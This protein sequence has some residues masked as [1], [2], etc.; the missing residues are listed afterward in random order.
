MSFILL[1]LDK[2]LLSH[3]S[4]GLACLRQC[5]YIVILEWRL[6]RKAFGIGAVNLNAMNGDK[7]DLT[8]DLEYAN[9]W[10]PSRFA[11]LYVYLAALLSS[12]AIYLL[13]RIQSFRRGR[14]E[15]PGSWRTK[16]R[17]SSNSPSPRRSRS[18]SRNK[19]YSKII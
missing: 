9:L 3:C 16:R 8:I 7:N 19:Y 4:R 6:H 1:P 12:A 10:L 2:A 18:S 14:R 5:V 11:L 13:G 17:S 15:Y